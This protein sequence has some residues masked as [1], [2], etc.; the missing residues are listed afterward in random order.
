MNT[1]LIAANILT[2]FTFIIHTFGGDKELKVNE[3]ADE[4]DKNF[5]K[6]KKWT[7]ERVVGV[8]C[9]L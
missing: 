7:V 2:F 4:I 6:R 8:I 3:P 1:I 5:Q 9:L